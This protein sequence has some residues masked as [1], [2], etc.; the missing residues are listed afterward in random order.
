MGLNADLDRRYV[1]RRHALCTVSDPAGTRCA[2]LS[3]QENRFH[4]IYNI[5]SAGFMK[6]MAQEP[7][8]FGDDFSGPRILTIARLSHQ[9]GA[10]FGASGRH[11]YEKAGLFVPLVYHRRWSE[12]EDLRMQREQLRLEDTVFFL[13]GAG[14]PV[15]L[16][17]C[18]RYQRADLAFEERVLRWTRRW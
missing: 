8:D 6:Q 12:E 17:P 3:G 13:G 1:D 15:S 16:P 7:A 14:Q 11:A 2:R 18:L 4:V 9:K 10:G 5:I